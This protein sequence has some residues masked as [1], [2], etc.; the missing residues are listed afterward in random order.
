MHSPAD[1]LDLGVQG[2]DL[3]VPLDAQP[4]GLAAADPELGR[5]LLDRDDPL[6][7]RAVAQDEEGPPAP[8]GLDLRLQ[9]GGAGLSRLGIHAG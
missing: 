4:G 9:L 1:H 6:L 8:F 5:A 2:G 3:L 7:A